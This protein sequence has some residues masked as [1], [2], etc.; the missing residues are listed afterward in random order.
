MSYRRE[1]HDQDYLHKFYREHAT[2]EPAVQMA[3]DLSEQKDIGTTVRMEREYLQA[4]DIFTKE[5]ER[6]WPSL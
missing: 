1:A 4:F 2:R 5:S 3:D 6:I